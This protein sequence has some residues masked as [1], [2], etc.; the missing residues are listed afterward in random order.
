MRTSTGLDGLSRADMAAMPSD[1][2]QLILQLCSHAEETGQW[3]RQAVLGVVSALDKRVDAEVVGDYRPITALSL[4]Y[5]VNLWLASVSLRRPACMVTLAAE[6][7]S[8][9]WFG[10]QLQLEEARYAGVGVVGAIADLEKAFNL[11]PRTPVMA[12][13]RAVGIAEPDWVVWRSSQHAQALSDP[14]LG[15]AGPAFLH[16]LS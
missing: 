11:L 12:A 9:L 13:A 5:P 3:P 4:L 16:R 2:L 14:W 1:L 10:L 15:W 8:Q 7:P 6:L